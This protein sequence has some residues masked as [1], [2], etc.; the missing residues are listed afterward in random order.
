MSLSLLKR[1]LNS[2]FETADYADFADPERIAHSFPPHAFVPYKLLP[3]P[4]V[5]PLPATICGIRVICG[6]LLIFG[7]QVKSKRIA[8]GKCDGILNVVVRSRR[9]RPKPR[10]RFA[11]NE[12]I[13]YRGGPTFT[14]FPS[15][16]C[17]NSE[18]R[19]GPS[20]DA[21]S[22]DV[23]GRLDVSEGDERRGGKGNEACKAQLRSEFKQIF[24]G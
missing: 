4:T 6:L 11:A 21:G 12:I 18:L 3:L 8:D 15:Q 2:E 9:T 17:L 5:S 13:G 14:R 7:F 20:R 16:S 19:V 1:K 24:F 23:R 22:L 10:T